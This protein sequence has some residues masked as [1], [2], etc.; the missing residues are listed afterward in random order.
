MIIFAGRNT[1]QKSTKSHLGWKTYTRIS[2]TGLISFSFPMM[3]IKLIS[4]NYTKLWHGKPCHS[5]V[6]SYT[7][8]HFSD[9]IFSRY[10]SCL[11]WVD[12]LRL[13]FHFF[14]KR[15]G[16][17]TIIGFHLI[18][19]IFSSFIDSDGGLF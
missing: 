9:K 1:M 3:Q 7:S 18:G 17:S 19:I 5:L 11:E 6:R 16:T 4:T 13:S 15:S 2:T 14:E 10:V 12:M 8:G